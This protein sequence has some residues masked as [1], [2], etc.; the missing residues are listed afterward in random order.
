MSGQV[1]S[2]GLDGV[3]GGV[4]DKL[5]AEHRTQT[6]QMM[7]WMN[8]W[9][10][11]YLTVGQFTY[12]LCASIKRVMDLEMQKSVLALQLLITLHI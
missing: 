3:T 5:R 1:L 12:M 9:S 6:H 4:Q 7:L 8:V 11:I 2:L 10:I